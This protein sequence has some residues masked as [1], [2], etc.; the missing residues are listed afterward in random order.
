VTA[1]DCAVGTGMMSNANANCDWPLETA[2]DYTGK[3][4]TFDWKLSSDYVDVLN[5]D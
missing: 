4:L 5:D 3:I 1:G 2:T